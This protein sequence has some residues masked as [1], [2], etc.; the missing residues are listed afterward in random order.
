MTQFDR[1]LRQGLMDANLEQYGRVLRNAED[2]EPDFSP[3]YLRERMRLLAAPQD[4]E[5][6]QARPAPRRRGIPRGIAA[7]I[8]VLLL[9]TAAAA[10][11]VSLW[12]SYFGRLDQRQQE[13][14]GDMEISGEKAGKPRAEKT[15]AGSLLPPPVKHGGV[16][17]TPLRILGAK[18]Q[19]YLVLEIR[20]PEGTVF[21]PEDDLYLHGSLRPSG[22]WRAEHP[23]EYAT[24]S[25][26]F[27]I[28]EAGTREPNVRVGVAEVMTSYDVGGAT[29][30]VWSLEQWTADGEHEMVFGG[31]DT[32]TG[33]TD[34]W[35][36]PIPEALNEDQVLELQVEGMS[37]TDGRKTMTLLS[38]NVTPLGIYWKYRLEGEDPWPQARLALRMKDGSEIKADSS[39]MTTGDTGSGYTAAVDFEKPVDLSQAEALLWEDLVI[40]LEQS[41]EK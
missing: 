28:L 34:Y 31:W 4:W 40:P 27:T 10:V 7:A 14:I 25:G 29:Y 23:K 39:Q 41:P 33:P 6:R 37:M 32:E 2:S 36:I 12:V 15:A 38:M 8:A 13:I 21:H 3:R 22:Q 30:R 26:G 18:S 35:E 20:A 24:N 17:I 11:T 16:T 5:R 19:L 9:V 1:L